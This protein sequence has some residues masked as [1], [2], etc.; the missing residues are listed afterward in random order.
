MM[1]HSI[2]IYLHPHGRVTDMNVPHNLLK[3]AFYLQLF[4]MLGCSEIQFK[5]FHAKY[6][7]MI[8]DV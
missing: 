2:A 3:W 5:L 4:V 7:T 6:F 8:Y 1:L